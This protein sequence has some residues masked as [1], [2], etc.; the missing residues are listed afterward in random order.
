MK[1]GGSSPHQ[2]GSGGLL[3]VLAVGV[4]LHGSLLMIS[5]GTQATPPAKKKRNHFWKYWLMGVRG[6]WTIVLKDVLL[7][8]A[9][10]GLSSQPIP[11]GSAAVV[12]AHSRRSVQM[13][14]VVQV[15]VERSSAE[16]KH[17]RLAAVL[18][19]IDSPPR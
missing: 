13:P 3:W 10:A 12:A 8:L 2:V 17:Q 7:M 6:S 1:A 5:S 4:G 11:R 9:V 15:D 19:A 18:S 16:I 14:S